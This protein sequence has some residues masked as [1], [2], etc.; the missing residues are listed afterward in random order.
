MIRKLEFIWKLL[1][2]FIFIVYAT[3]IIDFLLF[4]S[5]PIITY[6]ISGFV[7]ICFCY[8]TIIYRDFKRTQFKN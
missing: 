3:L 2:L 6:K 5:F 4:H 7:F 1:F 8:I